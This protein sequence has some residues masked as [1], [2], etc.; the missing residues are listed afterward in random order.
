MEQNQEQRRPRKDAIGYEIKT[1]S[2]LIRRRIDSA[3]VFSEEVTGMQGWIIGYVYRNQQKRDIFQKD[4]EAEFL[5]RR[6]TATGILQLMEKN[7][8]IIRVPVEY[9]ARLK[10]IVLTSKAVAVHQAVVK[11]LDH[12]EEQLALG[13]TK[14]E[15]DSFFTIIRKMK[16][17]VE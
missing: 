12:L 5:I 1:L 6:S 2:N 4:I 8:M 13:L 16:K 11:E 10:K 9:D 3:S 17:N 15:L 7:D 14:E